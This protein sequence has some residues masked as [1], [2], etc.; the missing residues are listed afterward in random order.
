VS[1]SL[2]FTIIWFM[3]WMKMRGVDG[4]FRFA[5]YDYLANGLDVDG[6]SGW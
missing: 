1:S 2:L 4:K 6:G 5:F 3:D